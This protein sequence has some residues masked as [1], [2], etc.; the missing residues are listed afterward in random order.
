[1]HAQNSASTSGRS[2][3]ENFGLP[4]IF[5]YTSKAYQG[6][7]QNHDAVQ[8]DK[9]IM[10]FGNLWGI[11]QFDGTEWTKIYLP[12]GA[13]CTSLTKDETG[14][15]YIGGRNEIGYLKTD[16]IGRK[17]Y[18]SLV[19]KLPD[20]GK[21]FNEVWATYA[22]PKGILFVSYEALLFKPKGRNEIQLLRKNIDN[23]FY[24]NNNILVVDK[25][26]LSILDGNKF[27]NMIGLNSL[28]NS[29]IRSIAFIDNKYL[30]ATENGLFVYDGKTYKVW[31]TSVNRMFASIGLDKIRLTTNNQLV[32]TSL[33]N[34]IVVTNLNGDILLHLNKATGLLGNA[35]SGCYVDKSNNLWLTSNA[36]ISYVSLS[37]NFTFLNDY[38][39]VTG[40]PHSSALYKGNIYLSTSEGLFKRKISGSEGYSQ[41][42][43]EKVQGISG[44]IWNLFV[45]DNKLF[46][47]QATGAYVIDGEEITQIVDQGTWLFHPLKGENLMLAGTYKGIIVLEKKDER[48]QYRNLIA[49]FN[50]SSRYLVEDKFGDI[51]ISHGNKGVFKIRLNK[52]LHAV[53]KINFYG[54]KHGLPADFDN[55]VYEIN[56]QIVICGLKGIFKYD[57][58]TEKIKPFTL[59]T[60]VLGIDSHIE[61]LYQDPAN[62]IWAVYNEGTLAQI[63]NTKNGYK[64]STETKQIRNN[65]VASFEHI[66]AMSTGQL[67]LGTQDGFAAYQPLNNTTK[68]VSTIFNAYVS[69]FEII[70]PNPELVWNGYS[71]GLTILPKALPYSKRSLKISFTALSFDDVQHTQFQFYLE[72]F[73]NKDQWSGLSNTSFKEYTNLREGKYYFHLRAINANGKISKENLFEFQISPPW[74]RTWIAY[75][76]Y[77]LMVSLFVYYGLIQTQKWLLAE[78]RKLELDKQRK[79]REKQKEWE[80][81]ALKKEN[82]LMKLQQEKLEIEATNLHQQQLLLEQKKE[83]ERELFAIQQTNL[84][85]NLLAKN[86]EL[87][88]L[89]IHIAQKNE[90]LSKIKNSLNKTIRDTAEEETRKDL[91][92][93]EQV[94]EKNLN[95]NKEW[96]KFCEHFD[97]VHE[98]FLKKLQHNYPDLKASSLK[99]CAYI[100]MRL[101]SKQIAVLLNTES[102]SVI[103]ARYRLRLKFNLQKELSLE[104]FLNQY[105][106]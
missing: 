57:Y 51:W 20:S 74:Y 1:M 78:K 44:L 13:S 52:S 3:F 14:T 21:A 22:T 23:A 7:P 70:S 11:L 26:G 81:A 53:S 50:E 25:Q 71:E 15:I 58:Q 29:F 69:K 32:F 88:S 89:T 68:G 84:E 67:I 63:V 2:G 45:F 96:E 77:L 104:E 106:S 79:L 93:I 97:L 59:L 41:Q 72:G 40:V 64:L 76:I 100:K 101:T 85:A 4:P 36:G 60:N 27:T 98:G 34:G 94:I 9:G 56:S 62:K 86:N 43:F 8:D 99:L 5:N 6:N 54:K 47:G 28:K 33:L 91:H 38:S 61:H 95:S 80:E 55:T 30:L 102:E 66:N 18:V 12:N 73:D 48:W 37:N 42:K 16:S 75:V 83:T 92:Q 39:G 10:Y 65:W 49:G 24:V 17:Q 46:C 82:E 103:K 19:S 35:I 87:T 31:N 90:V 105:V